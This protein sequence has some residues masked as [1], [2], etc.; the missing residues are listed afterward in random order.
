[1]DRDIGGSS[2]GALFG[3]LFGEKIN[4]WAMISGV[5]ATIKAWQWPIIS[6]LISAISLLLSVATLSLIVCLQ[7]V[8]PWRRRRKLRRP[9]DAYFSIPLIDRVALNY[10]QQDDCEHYV[11]ELVVPPN[12]KIPIQIVLAPKLSFLER[13]I[14]FGCGENVVDSE[15]PRATE[16]LVPFVVKG[17]R[18]SGKPDADHPGHYI[19]Y[20]GF[21]HVREDVLYTNDTRVIGFML[22]TR[23][24]GTYPAQVYTVTDEVRGQAD[25]TIRVEHPAK[26]KMRC[27]FEGHHKCFVAPTEEA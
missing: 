16:S 15:K 1:V 20:N 14:Y 17:V 9:F 24:T 12:S 22:V 19:D 3:L 27:Y 26:T 10:V 21:Y 23:A 25:L 13:E 8:R 5:L 2:A 6:A 4:M 11:K 7:I 18:K